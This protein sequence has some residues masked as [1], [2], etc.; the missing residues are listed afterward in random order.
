MEDNDQRKLDN[1]VIRRK[2]AHGRGR[3]LLGINWNRAMEPFY[4]QKAAVPLQ[5]GRGS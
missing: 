3:R 1:D 2:H 5:H 4:Y